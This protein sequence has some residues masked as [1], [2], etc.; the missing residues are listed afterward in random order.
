MN[1]SSNIF[2]KTFGTP[3][4]HN[5]KLKT[6]I[7]F[8][9]PHFV[10]DLPSLLPVF[11]FS[12]VHLQVVLGLPLLFSSAAQ[13]MPCLTINYVSCLDIVQVCVGPLQHLL[14]HL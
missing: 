9:G 12:T 8:Y 11:F 7:S 10:P 6:V 5:S 13:V 14:A 4:A 3:K 2:D 1:V